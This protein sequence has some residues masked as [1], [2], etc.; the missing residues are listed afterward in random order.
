MSLE[1]VWHEYLAVAATVATAI[2]IML[3]Y[4]QLRQAG[5]QAMIAFEDGLTEQYR[6]IIRDLPMA[7]LLDDPIDEAELRDSLSVFYQYFDL[8]NEQAFL[9]SRGRIRGKTWGDWEEG[10]R[11]NA[12]LR[13]F[14]AA[15]RT[16]RCKRPDVFDEIV[17]LFG[18]PDCIE[19]L[20]TT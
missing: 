12:R 18:E 5:E 15:W 1:S 16:I 13:A 9:R 19:R 20:D 7:A 10:I 3:A 2:G 6:R 17:G 11:Q 14:Q 8:S 4:W